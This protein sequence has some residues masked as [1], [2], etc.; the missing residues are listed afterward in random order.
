MLTKRQC[1]FFTYAFS[2]IINF[3]KS[4][5]YKSTSDLI[6]IYLSEHTTKWIL[7]SISTHENP[8]D[9]SSDLA[10]QRCLLMRPSSP[11][12][13][14]TKVLGCLEK[15]KEKLNNMLIFL[16]RLRC[17]TVQCCLLKNLKLSDLIKYISKFAIFFSICIIL[18]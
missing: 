11:A 16:D 14:T 12:T 3:S 8:K 18:I 1:L 15:K 10:N 2:W 7:S 13:N 6:I 9:V 5:V 4:L 17:R